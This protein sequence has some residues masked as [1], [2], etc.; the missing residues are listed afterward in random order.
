MDDSRVTRRRFILTAVIAYSVIAEP[1][2]WLSGN[3]AWADTSADTALVRLARR[4][5]P[6]AGLA[7][8]AYADV[9]RN[10]ITSFASNPQ[11]GQ[12]LD[13]AESALDKQVDG[14]WID[15]DE[16]SQIAAIRSIEGEGFFAAILAGMRGTFY[17]HPKV[18]AHL[19]YPGSSKEHGGYKHRGFDDI[20]WLPEVE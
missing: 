11:T 7:D 17:Y 10:L 19:D 20:S 3:I 5:F 2:G 6:H 8:D 9:V 4:L 13:L 1:R 16:D 18:W 12:L 15:A 14:D